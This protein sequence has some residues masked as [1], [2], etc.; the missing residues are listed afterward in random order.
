[1]IR[2]FIAL[3]IPLN[4]REEIVKLSKGFLPGIANYKWEPIEK[5]HLTLKFIGEVKEESVDSI[6]KKISFV[7]EYR[8]FECG[9]VNFGFFYRMSKPS[10]FFVRLQTDDRV[11]EVVKRLN[12]E[13]ESLGVQAEK[14]DFKVHLTLLRLKGYE[15]LDLLKEISKTELKG[16]FIADEI[17]LYKSR[18]LPHGSEYTELKSYKLR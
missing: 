15:D 13:F 8:K 17:V 3:K 11:N 2:L 9:L 12:S 6:I 4:I 14:K 7:E 10:I 1:M 18:L 16:T 5:I